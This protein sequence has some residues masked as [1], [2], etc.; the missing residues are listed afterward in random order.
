MIEKGYIKGFVDLV[1]EHDGRVYFADW[2]SDVL[3][4]YAAEMIAKHVDSI[5]RPRSSSTPSRW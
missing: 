1:V 3:P 2:K 5:M 4:S